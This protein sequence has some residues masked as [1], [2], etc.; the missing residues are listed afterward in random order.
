MKRGNIKAKIKYK[1]KFETKMSLLLTSL[2]TS[3]VYEDKGSVINYT[4]PESQHKYYPDW[5]VA[6]MI[7][8]TKGLWDQKDREKVLLVMEQHPEVDLRMVFENPKLPIYKGSKTTY[9]AWC[10]KKGIKWGTMADVPGWIK[11]KLNGK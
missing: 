7:L 1:S 5:L 10:D 4:I 8:E 9:A 6:G 11:A 2:G 3:F